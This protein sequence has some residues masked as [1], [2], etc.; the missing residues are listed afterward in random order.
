MVSEQEQTQSQAQAQR[1]WGMPLRALVIFMALLA[2][3][4][5]LVF[6]QAA[7]DTRAA[8]NELAQASQDYIQCEAAASDMKAG[9]NYLTIQVRSF[10]VTQDREY[11]DNYFWEADVNRRRD[12]AIETLESL[13]GDDTSSASLKAAMDESVELMNLEYYA[14]RLVCEAMG[15]DDAIAEHFSGVSLDAADAALSPDEKIALAQSIVFGDEYMAYVG[16]IEG[17]VAS[18]REALIQKIDAVQEQSQAALQRLLDRQNYLTVLLF[19]AYMA[20]SIAIVVLVLLPLRSFDSHIRNGEPLPQ[21]GA[22]ELRE[23]AASYNVMYE[24]NTHSYDV[25]RHKAEHD[26]LTGLFN[27]G[28]FERLLETHAADSYAIM[29]VDV[30]HFKGI[31]DS[32][33]HDVGDAALCK[34]ANHLKAAFRTSDYPCRI[35][36]DEF[37]VFMTEMTEELRYVVEAKVEGIREG[38]ADTSDGLPAITVSIGIAFNDGTLSGDKVFKHADQALFKVKE[39]GRDGFAFFGIE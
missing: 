9:S 28:V 21:T 26:T 17:N 33:G 5:A 24:E 16:E 12:N 32:L 30:D 23:L 31:N 36:G 27:R 2:A 22:R 19:A 39:A 20:I 37:V 13:Q 29:I 6:L 3:V 11:L 38:L 4:I 34:V 8:Y 25:L 18:C 1:G 14:M 15:Y 7:R 35:G 10:V